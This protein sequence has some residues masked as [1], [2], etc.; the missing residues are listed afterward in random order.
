MLMITEQQQAGALTFRLAGALAGDWVTELER[1]WC[2]ATRSLES[3]R[4]LVDLTE[5][6]FV[7]ETGKQLLTLM[8]QAGAELIA[9]DIL[10]KSIVE[11][12]ARETSI[13]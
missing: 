6:V 3:Q 5:V 10:M 8:A 2:D 9:S 13:A 4:I 1:C 11:E 12:I 7:D